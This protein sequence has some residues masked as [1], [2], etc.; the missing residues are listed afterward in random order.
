MVPYWILWYLFSLLCWRF[1]IK[2]TQNT[3][4]WKCIL[5]SMVCCLISGFVP[6]TYEFSFQRTFYF[7]PFFM[8]GHYWRAMENNKKKDK[9]MS[10]E[11]ACFI[12]CIALFSC[13]IIVGAYDMTFYRFL[14][15]S[16][17]YIGE[18]VNGMIARCFLC[19]VSFIVSLSVFSASK[20]F[21]ANKIALE[22]GKNTMFYL[23]YHVP[24]I[25]A[26]RIL[27][28]VRHIPVEFP[29]LMIYYIG[30]MSLLY[31][32]SRIRLFHSLLTPIS[33]ILQK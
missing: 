6:L 24:F 1:T 5:L 22:I 4:A 13:F 21:K 32:F 17:N 29:F 23:I 8:L 7:L 16:Y 26:I 25:L 28:S 20:L 19:V 9:R 18:G 33:Y 12:I 2:N 3:E 30:V 14:Y 15:G 11:L 10:S 31:I 27:I